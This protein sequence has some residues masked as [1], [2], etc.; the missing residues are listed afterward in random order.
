[1]SNTTKSALIGATLLACAM[2]S[3]HAV[4]IIVNGSF[5]SGNFIPNVNT[6]MQLNPGDTNLTGWTITGRDIIWIDSAS[7]FNIVAPDGVKSVDLT[8]YPNGAPY[9]TI[10]QTV[11]TIIGAKY[12][13][14]FDYGSN[15]AY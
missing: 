13:L 1:M 2:P 7:N 12:S 9:A 8:G 5:E 15:S 3:A 4:N 11:S 10:S 6:S 14:S